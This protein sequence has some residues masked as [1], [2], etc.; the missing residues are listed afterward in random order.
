MDKIEILTFKGCQTAVDLV[1]HITDLIQ[2]E[3]LDAGIETIIVPSLEK[4]AEMGLYG[5]PTI[6]VNGAEYQKQQFSQPGFY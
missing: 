5:S 2:S 3:N 1:Q 4:A 6:L